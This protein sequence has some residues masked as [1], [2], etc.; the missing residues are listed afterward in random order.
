MSMT[1]YTFLKIIFVQT[2]SQS[3]LDAVSLIFLQMSILSTQHTKLIIIAEFTKID[4]QISWN[5]YLTYIAIH[6]DLNPFKL[7]KS[8]HYIHSPTSSHSIYFI[9]NVVFC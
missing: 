2:V 6:C 9:L 4:L 5:I 3:I 1:T 8:F 7:L